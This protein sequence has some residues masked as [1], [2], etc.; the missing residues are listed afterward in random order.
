M[1][2]DGIDHLELCTGTLF[3]DDS[4]VLREVSQIFLSFHCKINF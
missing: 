1:L 2:S 4:Q 3:D